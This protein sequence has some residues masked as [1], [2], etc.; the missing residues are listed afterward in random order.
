MCRLHVSSEWFIPID[1]DPYDPLGTDAE[2]V[3]IEAWPDCV[4]ASRQKVCL[5]A[6][7]DHPRPPGIDRRQIV[8][9]DGHERVSLNVAVF[10]ALN[11]PVA[12]DVNRV[13]VGVV[14]TRH[15]H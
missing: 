7:L 2:D 13:L 10:L 6:D 1:T 8:D 5:S 9:H 14:A 11:K 3:W 12:A 15:G 4:T